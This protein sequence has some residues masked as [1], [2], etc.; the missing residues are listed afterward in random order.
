MRPSI[1]K[2][3]TGL[4]TGVALSCS[5]AV[6]ALAQGTPEQR[7]ACAGD[8][9]RL[10]GQFIPDIDRIKSCMIQ[11]RRHVSPACRAVREGGGKV[12]PTSN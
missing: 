6:V 2:E 12:R 11:M 10:C 8:A 3:I 5:F 1:R 7:I 4:T 9:T